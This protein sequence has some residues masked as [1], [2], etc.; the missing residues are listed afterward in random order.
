MTANL[1][2]AFLDKMNKLLG[3]EFPAFLASYEDPRYYG[4]RVNSL[5]AEPEDFLNISP[6][7]LRPIPWVKDGYYYSE[8]DRPG[9]H[10]YYHA[11]LYYIQ[12][13]SAMVPVEL[14]EVKPGE[15]VLDLCAAPGGKSTQISAALKGEGLIV[16]NDNAGERVKV[17]AKN[18]ELFGVR[19]AV[20]LNELP[21]RIVAAFPHY[22]DK[23]LIDAPCS[24]E[25]MFRK[26]EEMAGQWA[27]HSVER[28]V[29]MQRDILSHAAAL[30]AP[31]GRIVYSTCTFSPEENEEMIAEFLDNHM[32]FAIVPVP[33]SLGLAPGR[34][35]WI[36]NPEGE[37]TQKS[38]DTT[39]HT[40][41][42]W[43]H[44]FQ[45]EGH[46]FAILEHNGNDNVGIDR[47]HTPMDAD[48]VDEETVSHRMSK[49]LKRNNH[50]RNS[51]QGARSKPNTGMETALSSSELETV[52]FMLNN[53]LTCSLNGKF[54]K[55]GHHIYLSPLGVPELN[56]L[57]VARPGWFIGTLKKERFEPSHPL[58]LGLKVSDVS[59]NIYMTAEENNCIRYLKGE[60]V[61]VPLEAVI[62]RENPRE[63]RPAN[64]S[65]EAKGY[66][67]V[68]VDGYPMGWG[69]WIDGHLKN[70]YPAGWRIT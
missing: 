44:L 13:P 54:M 67:L 1:P 31:G 7:V 18:L 42:I 50:D 37:L 56:G 29:L 19:N 55:Y 63:E 3:P 68:C 49:E 5:K 58:A 25:G 38:M 35:E 64:N 59:R 57:K 8:G 69:K 6:F 14:L 46:F 11:G 51:K 53:L 23:I 22:F 36:P 33:V 47:V 62:V 9:K 12:E 60:T 26:D 61:S 39:R 41:R 40:G 65:S 15:K 70:E 32:D 28:C 4:L 27:K 66:T 16:A 17:L 2:Q 20:I 45:G 30:L 43:P 24:G 52:T 10:P 48:H 21:D 34:P